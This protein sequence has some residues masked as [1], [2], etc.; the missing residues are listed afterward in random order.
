[1]FINFSNHPCAQW[2]KKQI[3][4]A[5]KYG[6]ITDIEFPKI[7]PETSEKQI[8]ELSAEYA[9]KIINMKPAA[10]MCQGEYSL[11]FSVVLKLLYANILVVCACTEKC[12][13]CTHDGTG[14]KTESLF[15]FVKFRK[16]S[17]E[18]IGANE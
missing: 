16:Y 15:S 1:M 9:Q 3:K 6:K 8:E 13:I 12:D 10:V 7:T 17:A 11:T 5:E 18:G 14:T 4:E 2:S